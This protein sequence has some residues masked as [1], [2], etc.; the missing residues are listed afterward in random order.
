MKAFQ[1]TLCLLI[2]VLVAGC[3]EGEGDQ[4]GPSRGG[5]GGF[6]G[7][8]MPVEVAVAVR[9]TVVDAIYATGEIE[10]IQSIELRPEVE[11]RLTEILVREGATVS[12]GTPLFRIDDAKT[13]A[14][15]ARLTAERDLAVQALER[16]RELFAKEA[17]SKSEM[18]LAEANFR[19]AEARLELEQVRLNRTIVR[20]P[21]SGIVGERFVSLGDYLTTSTP[22]TTLQTFDPQRAAFEVPERYARRVSVGQSVTF[23]VA[24]TSDTYTGDVD[25]VNPVVQLPGRTIEVK[26]LVPNQ[27]RELIPG[28]FIDVRLATEVRADAIVVPEDAILPLQGADYVWVV[29]ADTASRKEVQLGVR[30]PGFVEIT[31]GV[32]AGSQVVVGGLERLREGAAVAPTV[33]ERGRPGRG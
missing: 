7:F 10:A 16:T 28:M 2:G 11:G 21:F 30:V 20:A 19:S 3:G 4:T 9:D 8:T 23:T 27:N 1:Y 12:A 29:A 25:F 26:A 33:V 17:S 18:E 5:G 15:V 31:S 13:K 32:E 24:A 22:L 14:D 6:T